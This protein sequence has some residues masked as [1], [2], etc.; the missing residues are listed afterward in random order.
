M[1][2]IVVITPPNITL[3]YFVERL[4]SSYDVEMVSDDRIVNNGDKYIAINLDDYIVGEY[5][6]EEL[7]VISRVIKPPKFFLIEFSHLDFLK[8]TIPFC[9]DD[10][11]F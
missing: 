3:K 5:D 9:V 11:G 8:E 1:Q 4:D 6:E 2:N 7:N 10:S